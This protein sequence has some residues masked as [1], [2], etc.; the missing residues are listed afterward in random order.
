MNIRDT[1]VSSELLTHVNWVKN[2]VLKEFWAVISRGR[3]NTGVNRRL[4]P[5]LCDIYPSVRLG[6]FVKDE[7]MERNEEKGKC[8]GKAILNRC[9]KVVQCDTEHICQ[10]YFFCPQALQIFHRWDSSLSVLK[11]KKYCLI[12]LVSII[13]WDDVFCSIFY[14]LG[15]DFVPV[16][17]G[18]QLDIGILEKGLKLNLL[19]FL[20]F[21]FLLFSHLCFS[22]AF[23]FWAAVY[24]GNVIWENILTFVVEIVKLRM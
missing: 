3:H 19:F 15:L 7:E 16:W 18:L 6:K 9:L 24:D 5:R 23:I 12:W 8:W 17:F 14:F 20:C 2:M 11:W 1:W 13:L 4:L 10:M 21:L 22:W